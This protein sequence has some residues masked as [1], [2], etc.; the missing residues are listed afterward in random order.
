MGRKKRGDDFLDGPDPDADAG[1]AAADEAVVPVT[2]P[3]G[4][5]GKKGKAAAAFAAG[6]GPIVWA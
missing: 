5:K 2:K 4:K 6:E 1:E 3:K